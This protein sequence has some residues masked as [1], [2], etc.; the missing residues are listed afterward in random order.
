MASPWICP[1]LPSVAW[2][3]H[4]RDLMHA[5]V[6]GWVQCPSGYPCG[7]GGMLLAMSIAF[8]ERTESQ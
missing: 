7:T 5:A 8:S 2:S 4:R 1:M 6:T 3:A